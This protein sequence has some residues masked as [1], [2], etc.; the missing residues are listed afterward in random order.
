MTLPIPVEPKV[1]SSDIGFTSQKYWREMNVLGSLHG[2]PVA[3]KAIATDG[4]LVVLELS[5]G[6]RF[7]GHLNNFI[8]VKQPG[9]KHDRVEKIDVNATLFE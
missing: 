2:I 9:A 3:G 7:T 1:S 6:S 4:V 8:R 5:D